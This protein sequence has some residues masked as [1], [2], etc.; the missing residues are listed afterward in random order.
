LNDHHFHYGYFIKAAAVVSMY[1]ITWSKKWRRMINSLVNDVASIEP[2]DTR[3]PRLRYFDH[4]VSHSYASGHAAFW[5]GNNQESS[6]EA[7]NSHAAIL[8]WASITNQVRMRNLAIYLYAAE[9]TSIGYYWFNTKKSVFPSDYPT[10]YASLVWDDGSAHEIFWG[11]PNPEELQGINLLPVTA[12]SLYL[13]RYGFA[14]YY[15]FLISNKNGRQEELWKDII[16][17]W[18][19]LFQPYTAQA[20]LIGAGN[21]NSEPG[22]TRPFTNYFINANKYTGQ[23]NYSIKCDMPH[24]IAFKKGVYAAYNP[25]EKDIRV[26]FSDGLVLQVRARSFAQSKR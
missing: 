2:R 21:Y 6:S 9:S 19:S 14:P 12:A 17:M 16:W 25:T 10:P 11:P 23:I 18:K 8:L 26:T 1:D 15:N 20:N 3:F 24:C 5:S 22:T 13:Q 4:F 7:M